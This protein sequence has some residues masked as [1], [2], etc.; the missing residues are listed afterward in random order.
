MLTLQRM[1]EPLRTAVCISLLL[2]NNEVLVLACRNLIASQCL[3]AGGDAIDLPELQR[4][5][6]TVEMF[7]WGEGRQK[8]VVVTKNS[9]NL[10]C[11]LP[12][13]TC[14]TKCYAYFTPYVLAGM[15]KMVTFTTLVL[16]L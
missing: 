16:G 3:P 11:F 12:L 15:N 10:T 13:L 1:P 5:L 14:M 9:F 2:P 8:L 7:G 4:P 6:L